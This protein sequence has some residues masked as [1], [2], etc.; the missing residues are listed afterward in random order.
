MTQTK[1]C[2][3]CGTDAVEIKGDICGTCADALREE[4]DAL[5]L[6]GY[7]IIGRYR[8]AEMEGRQHDRGS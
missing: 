1:A 7:G 8:L 5:S 2:Q 6:L 3:R 4:A